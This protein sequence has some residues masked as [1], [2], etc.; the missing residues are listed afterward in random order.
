MARTNGSNG[1]SVNDGRL[2]TLDKTID[3]LIKRFG[4]GTIMRLGEGHNL[5]IQVCLLYTSRCV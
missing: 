3:S 4:E 5:H 2:A 1:S